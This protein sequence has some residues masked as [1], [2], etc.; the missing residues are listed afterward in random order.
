[1]TQAQV[2]VCAQQG[3]TLPTKG[4]GKYCKAHAAESRARF[5]ALMQAS[6]DAQDTRRAGF[7]TAWDGVIA[8]AMQGAQG[9]GGWVRI[10]PANSAVAYWAEARGYA[11]KRPNAKGMWV[12][13]N[14][15]AEVLAQVSAEYL[16]PLDAR[17]RFAYMTA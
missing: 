15:G 14:R 9:A 4:K 17:A 13:V 7:D 3:C 12:R 5:K 8:T 16:T 2:R 11:Q 6:K 1:M 10:T